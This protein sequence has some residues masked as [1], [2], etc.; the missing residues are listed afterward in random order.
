MSRSSALTGMSTPIRRIGAGEQ[1][2]RDLDPERFCRLEVDDHLEPRRLLDRKL[3][4]VFAGQYPHDVFGRGAILI[5]DIGSIADQAAALGIVAP[6]IDGGHPMLGRAIDDQ[7]PLDGRKIRAATYHRALRS[8]H[9]GLT[10]GAADGF[11]LRHLDEAIFDPEHPRGLV[12]ARREQLPN[13]T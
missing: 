2:R 7:M 5:L 12:L 10:H 4:R 8:F 13:R 3:T 11:R 9:K 1:C 6:L